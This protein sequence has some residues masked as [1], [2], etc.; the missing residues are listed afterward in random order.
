MNFLKLDAI[1]NYVIQLVVVRIASRKLI[2]VTPVYEGDPMRCEHRLL[3]IIILTI[4]HVAWA[5]QPLMADVPGTI[6]Y[7]GYL[8]ASNQATIN[9]SKSITF[10]LYAADVGGSAL[11]SEVQTT[12]VSKG[13]FSVQL[14]TQT[15]FPVGLFENKTLYL[16]IKVGSEAEMTPRRPFQNTPFA[17][18]A[19]N[20]D[21]VG[22]VLASELALRTELPASSSVTESN[23]KTISISSGSVLSLPSVITIN[24]NYSRLNAGNT[25]LSGGGF[26]GAN[27]TEILSFGNNTVISNASFSNLLMDGTGITFINCQF[28]G[29]LRLP[30]DSVVINS[31]FD[32]VT[33]GYTFAIGEIRNSQ[34]IGS[35]L[36]RVNWISNSSISDST[37]GNTTLNGGNV[38]RMFGNNVNNSIIYLQ[39]DG[40]ASNNSFNNS[41][42]E[43]LNIVNGNIKISGNRFSKLLSGSSEIIMIRSNNS[44]WRIYMISDNYFDMQSSDPAAIRIDGASSNG[45][46]QNIQVVGNSFTQG[47]NAI[48]HSGTI[49]LIVRNNTYMSISLGVATGGKILVENN[50]NASLL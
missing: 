14:G 16:G 23:Y 2:V 48:V 45:S 47:E 42:I 18:K 39:S 7:Q 30:H 29:N 26:A 38:S 8:S 46:F 1:E 21:R 6:G 33:T 3:L 31:T 35:T 25:I 40:Q 43:T 19:A 20:A 37:L 36:E 41:R 17:M 15:A 44:W 28:S 10:S 34:I 32:N 22:G 13:L 27:G 9:D 4:V 50:I 12:A 11:W 5:S 49:P 24:T